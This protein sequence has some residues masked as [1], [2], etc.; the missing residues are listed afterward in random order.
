MWFLLVFKLYTLTK[1][2]IFIL[3]CIW[4]ILDGGWNGHDSFDNNIFFFLFAKNKLGWWWRQEKE[5]KNEKERSLLSS[6]SQ[7]GIHLDD[8][9][10]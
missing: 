4:M 5:A 1:L 2:E 9:R 6:L 10:G 7:N 8:L 3:V